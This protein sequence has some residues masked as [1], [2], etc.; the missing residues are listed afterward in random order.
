M[1]IL[2]ATDGSPHSQAAV[3]ILRR[4]PFPPGSDLTVVTVVEQ[5]E[6]LSAAGMDMSTKDR[7]LFNHLHDRRRQEAER[8]LAQEAAQ[9][10]GSEWTV[11][12]IRREGHIAPQI[13]DAV[14]ELGVDLV[15]LGARGVSGLQRFLLGS[16]SH[17]VVKYAPCDVLVAKPHD[18][19]DMETDEA[20]APSPGSRLR[21]LM[22]YD[23]SVPAEA[24]VQTLASLP[25]Q[26]RA[27]IVVITVM[28]LITAF[29]MDI[30]QQLSAVWQEDKQAAQAALET[31]AQTLRQATPHVST[32]LR[33]GAE[34]SQEILTAA[35]ECHADLIMLGHK[36]KSGIERFLLGSTANRVLH[37]AP[38][39]V[40]VVKE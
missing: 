24:A 25:L 30:Q 16:V 12:A 19:V 10:E 33:E 3:A 4:I 21:I 5:S 22:A 26:D 1:K 7:D 32:E 40:W 18:D 31:V 8:L 34:P 13:L 15:V 37:Y 20:A 39:C 38:C 11:R 28:T 27:E 14:D 6:L 2:L 23:G 29:R 36:G 17:K 9:I 35:R